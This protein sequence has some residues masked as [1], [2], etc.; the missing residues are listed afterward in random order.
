[1]SVSILNN[2]D[3]QNLVKGGTI[4]IHTEADDTLHGNMLEDYHKDKNY[5]FKEP[6][7]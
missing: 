3:F 1:M 5:S 6:H 4:S 7:Y 2:S